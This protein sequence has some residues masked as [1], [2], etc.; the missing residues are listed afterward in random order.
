MQDAIPSVEVT[1]IKV[2]PLGTSESQGDQ[3]GNR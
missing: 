1:E 2:L 3:H